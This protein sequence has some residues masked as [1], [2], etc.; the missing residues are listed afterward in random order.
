MW[1][2]RCPLLEKTAYPLLQPFCKHCRTV[3]RSPPSLLLSRVKRPNSF[4]LSSIGQVLH[5]LMIY[6]ALLWTLPSLSMSVLNRKF[7]KKIKMREQ[8]RTCHLKTQRTYHMQGTHFCQHNSEE[9]FSPSH[10]G[11]ALAT[12]VLIHH[13]LEERNGEYHSGKRLTTHKSQTSL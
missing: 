4:S 11:L 6:R 7:K 8:D 9:V 10:I 2:W 13:C 1:M 5:H 3:M 12:G